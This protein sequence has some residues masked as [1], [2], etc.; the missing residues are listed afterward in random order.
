MEIT[1][2]TFKIPCSVFEHFP[3]YQLFTPSANFSNL[4]VVF[5]SLLIR[6][7]LWTK[8][9]RCLPA[10][11]CCIRG[12]PKRCILYILVHYFLNKIF[13]SLYKIR[14][15]LSHIL[16]RAVYR[17]DTARDYIE[18]S[19]FLTRSNS[20]CQWINSNLSSWALVCLARITRI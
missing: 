8:P 14:S 3:S 10:L 16:H 15:I 6:Q 19:S 12:Y 4:E 18:F 20:A 11:L 1:I 9:S 13:S 5:G 17:L 2:I 7:W